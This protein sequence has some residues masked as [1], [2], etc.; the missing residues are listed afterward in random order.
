MILGAGNIIKLEG[1][2][3][4]YCTACRKVVEPLIIVDEE[5]EV[6]SCEECFLEEMVKEGMDFH[7]VEE[8][9][10]EEEINLAIGDHTLP[11][12]EDIL[13]ENYCG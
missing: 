3:R 8:L 6:F 1:E 13:C 5:V 2:D 12:D 7:E 10:G 9:E 11:D 4:F